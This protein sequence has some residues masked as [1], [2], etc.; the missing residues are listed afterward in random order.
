MHKKKSLRLL[1]MQWQKYV[2]TR[3]MLKCKDREC[4]HV[5]ETQ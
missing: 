4:A 3:W 5:Y 1:K 2:H